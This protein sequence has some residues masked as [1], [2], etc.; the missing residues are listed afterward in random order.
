MPDLINSFGH[1]Q[2]TPRDSR[3]GYTSNTVH[4]IW[5]MDSSVSTQDP[6]TEKLDR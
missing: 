1:I 3:V 5:T 2:K 6:L 4:I